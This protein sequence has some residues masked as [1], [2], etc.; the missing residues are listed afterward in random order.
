[1]IRAL[2]RFLKWGGVKRDVTF[3]V[4]SGIALLIS[5]LDLLPQMP[6]DAAVAIGEVFAAG[7]VAFI[8]QLGSL[9][10][11]LTVSRA[12]VTRCPAAQ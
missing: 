3:L 6:F 7:E 5:I 9:P 10:E 8:M 4:L 2:E 1:M 11:N 12:R